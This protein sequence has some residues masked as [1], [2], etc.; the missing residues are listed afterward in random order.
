MNGTHELD[1][2]SLLMSTVIAI[3]FA[4]NAIMDFWLVFSLGSDA[5]VARISLREY[6]HSM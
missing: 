2:I 4:L 3:A 1:N 6:V 5:S